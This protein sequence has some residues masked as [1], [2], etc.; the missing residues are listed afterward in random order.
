MNSNMRI[1]HTKEV[2]LFREMMRVQQALVKQ[3]V[4]AVGEYYL[5]DIHKHTTDSISDTVANVLTH[6]PKK[7]GKI[8][9]H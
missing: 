4:S 1:A 3:I 5:A 2:R 9:L 6:I 8:I 7:Y